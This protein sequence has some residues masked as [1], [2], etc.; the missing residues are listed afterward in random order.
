[1][2][3]VF[4]W[5]DSLN[6]KQPWAKELLGCN[7]S[8]VI[9]GLIRAR[10][11][12]PAKIGPFCFVDSGE[13]PG[14]IICAFIAMGEEARKKIIPALGF[15]IFSMEKEDGAKTHNVLRNIFSIIQESKLTELRH[16]LQIWMRKRHTITSKPDKEEDQE[17]FRAALMAY[18]RVQPTND[19]IVEGYWTNL[20]K[21]GFEYWWPVAFTGMR[22]QNPKLACYQ[23][24]ILIGRNVQHTENLLYAMW[25]D[26]LARP[27]IERA[28]ANG[29]K[30]DAQWAGIAMAKLAQRMNHSDKDNLLGALKALQ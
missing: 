11:E 22:I 7:D 15:L 9:A 1:M 6:R 30:E 3:S 25:S 14:D 16:Q 10:L 23:L 26:K 21:E 4:D 18:T 20:W 8:E 24:P 28:L 12:N 19:D 2:R 5:T 17:T 13:L 29:L 27:M